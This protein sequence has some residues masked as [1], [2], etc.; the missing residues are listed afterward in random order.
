MNILYLKNILV[1]FLGPSKDEGPNITI[2]GATNL[3]LKF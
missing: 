3:I 1:V 2:F